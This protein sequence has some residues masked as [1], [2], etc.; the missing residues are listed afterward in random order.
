MHLRNDT[1]ALHAAD[2]H[3]S[4]APHGAK[5]AVQE[6]PT[7]LVAWETSNYTFCNPERVSL[8]TDAVGAP[9][10]HGQLPQ[11]H[12]RCA[13]GAQATAALMA[14]ESSPGKA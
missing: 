8:L 13:L 10:A 5:I 14:R 11:W 9:F 3:R 4:D 2:L 12:Q 7:R 1:P 6:S